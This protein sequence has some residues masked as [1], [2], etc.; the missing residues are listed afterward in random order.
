MQ[1]NYDKIAS[2]WRGFIKTE[3]DK[4]YFKFLLPLLEVEYETKD[5]LPAWDNVFNVFKTPPQDIRVVILGQ[6]PYPTPGDAMGLAFSVSKDHKLPR[7]L[8]NIFKE[9]ADETTSNLRTNGDLSDWA[10]QG[11]F[12]L[13][14]VLTVRAG[15]AASHRKIGWELFTDAVIRYLNEL[16][17]PIV[18]ML[19]GND[20]IKKQKLLTNA[21]HLVLTAAHPSPLSA[22]R[23]F[24]GCGHFITANNFLLQQGLTPINW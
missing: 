7:S 14:T 22:S 10:D 9:I 19:W 15:E 2:Q 18:F 21:N 23:G 24:F 11:V 12:L 8:K 20:A 4:D 16:D 1:I 6:D 17:Q 13:N 5:I 3:E